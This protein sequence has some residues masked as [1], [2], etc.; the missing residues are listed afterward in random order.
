ME[1]LEVGNLGTFPSGRD[2]SDDQTSEPPYPCSP[3]WVY[4]LL[5]KELDGGGRSR[6]L[7]TSNWWY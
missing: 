5:V 6:V 2:M 4:L 7:V 3:T 1:F